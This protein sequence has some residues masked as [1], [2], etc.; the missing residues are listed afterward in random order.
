[1]FF[2][3]HCRSPHFIRHQRVFGDVSVT[4]CFENIINLTIH[5]LI[6]TEEN[7][8]GNVTFLALNHPDH[9][10]FIL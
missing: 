3:S 4:D 5:C 10:S 8:R 6:D 2:S 9:P 7:I 1:M